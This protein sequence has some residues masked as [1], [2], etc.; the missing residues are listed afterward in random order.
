[1]ARNRIKRPAGK[2]TVEYVLFRCMEMFLQL[3]P[4]KSVDKLG[5]AIGS[6]AEKILPSRRKI[7]QRNLRIAWGEN[8]TKPEILQLSKSIFSQ[9]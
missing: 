3:L 2:N 6:F 5:S 9:A 4:I 8:L 7:V 1:M